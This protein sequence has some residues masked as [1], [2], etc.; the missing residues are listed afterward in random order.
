MHYFDST[1][2]DGPVFLHIVGNK[3]NGEPL[4]L[5][6]SPLNLNQELRASLQRYF[7]SHFKQ[8]EYYC[9]T[10]EASLELNEVYTYVAAIFDD[11]LSIE[12]QS[13]NI[14]KTL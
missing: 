4:V 5:T 13:K 6:S 7:L 14:A 9:F 2:I 3:Q 10:H 12:Q 8:M 1:A 11:I